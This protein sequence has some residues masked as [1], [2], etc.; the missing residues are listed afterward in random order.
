MGASWTAHFER[1]I[2]HVGLGGNDRISQADFLFPGHQSHQT[3]STFKTQLSC[4]GRDLD[5]CAKKNDLVYH[6]SAHVP[7]ITHVLRKAYKDF[8]I[9]ACN[10]FLKNSLWG[11]LHE[12]TSLVKLQCVLCI[13]THNF[14]LF[15]FICKINSYPI[16]NGKHAK[17]CFISVSK[18]SVAWKGT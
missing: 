13:K 4:L 16:S 6:S 9:M 8:F 15:T 14:I 17:A 1:L 3:I 2:K 18:M 5:L 12:E 7:G 11:A 10:F